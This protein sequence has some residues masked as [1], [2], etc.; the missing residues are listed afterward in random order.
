[1]IALIVISV[2][3]VQ[4]IIGLIVIVI[5]QRKKMKKM[6]KDNNGVKNLKTEPIMPKEE[7]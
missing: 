6:N 7:L 2:F 4:I 3:C 5:T 1:M